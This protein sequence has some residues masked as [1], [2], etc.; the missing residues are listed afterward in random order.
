MESLA[1]TFQK[2]WRPERDSFGPVSWPPR[3][4]DLILLDYFLLGY[5]KSVVYAVK[6]QTFDHLEDNIRRVVADVRP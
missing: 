5:A 3:S 4:C 2:R 1:H 6:P